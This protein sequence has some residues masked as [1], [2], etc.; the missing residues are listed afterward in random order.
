MR[1]LWQIGKMG[2]ASL[3]GTSWMKLLSPW[4]RDAGVTLCSHRYADSGEKLEAVTQAPI[5]HFTVPRWS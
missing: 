2:F 3:P 4:R 1:S 5:V